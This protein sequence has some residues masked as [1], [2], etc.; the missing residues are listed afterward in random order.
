M[1]RYNSELVPEG[2]EV[3]ADAIAPD[4]RLG[5]LLEEIVFE[6]ELFDPRFAGRTAAIT[7]LDDAELVQQVLFELRTSSAVRGPADRQ[8]FDDLWLYAWPVLKAF[9]RT[10]RMNQV[11]R[12]YLPHGVAI[13]PEDMVTLRHSEAERDALSID[14]ISRAVVHFRKKAIIEQKW[15]PTGKAS[16]RTWFIG[17][18]ALAF[19]RA[20]ERWSTERTDRLMEMSSRGMVPVR[21]ED[22]NDLVAEMPN[23]AD[24]ALDRAAL[25]VLLA[26][27]KPETRYILG[28]IAQGATY[29]EIADELRWSAGAV[30]QRI[31]RL[32]ERI[33]RD[34]QSVRDAWT[35]A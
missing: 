19:P 33:R 10:T 25:Q 34:Q 4:G 8:L 24:I 1:I 31:H 22:L 35:A 21:P 6:P 28:R 18:C 11:V 17:S 26:K 7:R 5:D 16:L 3:E 12:R 13:T 9:L 27:I 23:P 29:Q 20:Y 30:A 14:V 32:R 15:S 2:S